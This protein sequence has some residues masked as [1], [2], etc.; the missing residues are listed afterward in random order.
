VGS[1]QKCIIWYYFLL[2]L[3]V[4]RHTQSF[5]I[6][7]LVP[8]CSVI[9]AWLTAKLLLALA[10]KVILGS[11]S[12]G[13]HYHILLPD[14]SGSLHSLTP[15]WLWLTGL[16]WSGK[17]LYTTLSKNANITMPPKAPWLVHTCYYKVTIAPWL[18]H[19]CCQRHVFTMMLPRNGYIHNNSVVQIFQF[20]D[21]KTSCH[22]ST[23][24]IPFDS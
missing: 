6:S 16:V 21:L 14:G 10:S 1:G 7:C 3:A 5:S 12:H 22:S 13:T 9:T 19:V 15:L 18:P 17:L 20:M 23:E 4:Y 8:Q 2:P 24:R 11:K